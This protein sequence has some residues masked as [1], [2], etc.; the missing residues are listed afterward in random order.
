MNFKGSVSY[1][2]VGINVATWIQDT[3]CITKLL[4]KFEYKS[5]TWVV[6]LV[7]FGID[8][9]YCKSS[10]SSSQLLASTMAN[11]KCF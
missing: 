4:A 7:D 11:E 2:T 8:L 3:F 1:S 5:L 9:D 6:A 10:F